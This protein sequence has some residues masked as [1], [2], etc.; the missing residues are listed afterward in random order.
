MV[1]CF[2]CSG[3]TGEVPAFWANDAKLYFAQIEANLGIAGIVSEQTE[4]DTLVE[5]LD[6]QTLTH[7]SDLLYSPLTDNPYNALKIGLLSEFEISQNKSVKA[8]LE[9]LDLGDSKSSLL[10]R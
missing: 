8:L 7:V 4:F 6:P 2:S 10:L 9:D 5:A 1:I 3:V